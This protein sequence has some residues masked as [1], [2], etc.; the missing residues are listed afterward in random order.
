MVIGTLKKLHV[1]VYMA[2]HI[3]M[4]FEFDKKIFKWLQSKIDLQNIGRHICI[5]K[6]ELWLGRNNSSN[7]TFNIKLL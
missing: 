1:C 7:L 2:I 6:N 5:T 4:V 3:H